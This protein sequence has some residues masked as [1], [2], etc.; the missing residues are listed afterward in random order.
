M[1]VISKKKSAMAEEEAK[2]RVRGYAQEAIR[3][4]DA[5]ENSLDYKEASTEHGPGFR[6]PMVESHS[7]SLLDS[8]ASPYGIIVPGKVLTSDVS[9]AGLVAI[10]EFAPHILGEY[11]KAKAPEIEPAQTEV[12]EE[13]E[14]TADMLK[15]TLDQLALANQELRI[16]EATQDKNTGP[17]A[18]YKI[19]L[20]GPFGSFNGNFLDLELTPYYA[21]LV[22][23]IGDAVFI[24]PVTPK[25]ETVDIADLENNKKYKVSYAGVSFELPQFNAGFIVF[26]LVE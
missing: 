14:E 21:I 15:E 16:D 13:L 20:S 7:R 25:G 23:I 2:H 4:V 18:D 11:V 26:N 12:P 1:E 19:Q 17:R 6:V 9:G 3:I 24:P 8:Q 10:A 22:Y 5:D